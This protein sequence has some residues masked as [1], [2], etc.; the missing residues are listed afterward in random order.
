[1]KLPLWA[2]AL[3]GIAVATAILAVSVAITGGFRI[4]VFGGRLSITEWWRPLLALAIVLIVRH[5]IVREQPL[6]ARLAAGM[7]RWWR[8]DDTRAVLPIHLGSR[9]GVLLICF[10]AVILIGFPP[11]ASN[12]WRIY[13]NDLLDLP[14]RWDAGWYLG[15]ANTGYSYA[16]DST[17]QY[18][19]NIAFFPAYPMAMR[20]VSPLFGRHTL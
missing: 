9:L 2:R 14:A 5:V 4:T 17:S 13:S 1:M 18:Q 12:R 10:A 3:D 8:A 19:Q 7:A 20:A 16:S 15:I 6:P 11:E